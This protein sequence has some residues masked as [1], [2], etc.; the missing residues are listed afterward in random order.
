MS[1][2]L[3]DTLHALDDEELERFIRW[4][5]TERELRIVNLWRQAQR[6]HQQGTSARQCFMHAAIAADH[7]FCAATLQANLKGMITLDGTEVACIGIVRDE[8]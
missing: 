6:S 3:Q 5:N 1:N 8:C 7:A 4:L 2:F